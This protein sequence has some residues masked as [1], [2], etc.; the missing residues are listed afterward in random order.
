MIAPLAKLIEWLCVQ[1]RFRRMPHPDGQGPRLD[2]AIEFLKGPEYIPRES[3]SAQLVFDDALHFHFPTPRPGEFLENN[4]A[5]GQLY[6]CTERWQERPTIILLHG[7][8][9]SSSY[10]FQFPR[11]ACRC[12]RMGFNA[13][14]LVAPYHFQRRPE[15]FR[16]WSGSDYLQVAKVTAQA[17]AEIRALIGW[18]LEQGCPAVAVWGVSMGGSLAGLVASHDARLAA[19]V[20]AVPGVG[21]NYSITERIIWPAV[22]A[23]MLQQRAAL[24]MLNLTPLNLTLNQPAISRENILLIEAIHDLRV[25]KE[26]IEKLW[27]AWGQTDIW[28]LPHGH[29]T[30]MGLPGLNRIRTPALT[31]EILHWLSP[32]LKNSAYQAGHTVAAT[33][34]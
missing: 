1:I 4:V 5:Y 32:R 19:A 11:M 28:R 8:N 25:P 24:E 14:T 12:K 34:A 26:D 23:A 3:Q 22:R 29:S 21:V 18:L 33:G 31:D 15:Q 20:L 9:D 16:D 13:A 6:R 30:W 7:K 27:Q 17:V 2:E 10:R